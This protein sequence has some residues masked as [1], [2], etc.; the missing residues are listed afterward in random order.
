MKIPVLNQRAEEAMAIDVFEEDGDLHV[1]S[2]QKMMRSLS[3]KLI[4]D[5][6]ELAKITAN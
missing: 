6:Q 4:S 5:H 1:S 2:A 3:E